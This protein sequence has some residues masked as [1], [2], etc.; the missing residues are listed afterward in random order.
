LGLILAVLAIGYRPYVPSQ[1]SSWFVPI[2]LLAVPI[3]DTVLIVFSRVR[4]KRAVYSAGHDHTYH[5][6]SHIFQS[7]TRAVLVM[8]MA[9]FILGCLAFLG[10][11]QPPFIANVIFIIALSAGAVALVWLDG[12]DP[13]YH[14]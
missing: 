14:G 12:I 3:F 8:Q 6:L 9:A 5:R 1:A 10:L 7:S 11:N 13:G 2:M 4:R